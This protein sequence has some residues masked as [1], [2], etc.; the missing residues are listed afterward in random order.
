MSIILFI[1]RVLGLLLAGVIGLLFAVLL[2]VLLVPVRYRGVVR[3][4]EEW[5]VRAEAGWFCRLFRIRI[6]YDKELSVQARALFFLLY[7]TDEEWKRRKEEKKRVRLKK[8]ENAAKERESREEETGAQREESG[9]RKGEPD[10][11]K[12]ELK[13]RKEEPNVRKD[14][15]EVQGEMNQGPKVGEGRR[16]GIRTGEDRDGLPEQKKEPAQKEEAQ[17]EDVRK[18]E[19]ENP[20]PETVCY[21][22]EVSGHRIS[23]KIRGVIQKLKNLWNSVKKTIINII[24]ILKKGREGIG[25]LYQKAAQVKRFLDET[26]HKEAFRLILRTGRKFLAHI[27]P[28]RIRG[29]FEFGTGDPCSTGQLLGALSILYAKTGGGF[30]VIPDFEETRYEGEISF[31]G[32]IR[33]VVL[34]ILT[35]RLVTDK[36]LRMLLK[37]IT[38]LR[39]DLQGKV[40]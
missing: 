36:N 17:E 26:A 13:V 28:V 31:R 39:S 5:Y 14:E 6:L 38:R 10:A 33:G 35:I 20:A 19:Q 23:S 21:S 34:L 15:A 16:E 1:L 12:E 24:R 25:A 11:P 2:I 32:R 18:N 27:L 40:A 37:D 22:A 30:V 7:S 29:T 8:A 4:H 9:T 3:K